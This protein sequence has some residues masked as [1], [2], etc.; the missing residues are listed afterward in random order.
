MTS[1]TDRPDPR[2][3]TGCGA[4]SSGCQAHLLFRATPR[5]GRCEHPHD[6]GHADA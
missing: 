4:T 1:P 5:C 6:L 3:C 2:T